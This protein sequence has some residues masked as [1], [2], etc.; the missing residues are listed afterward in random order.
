MG[1]VGTGGPRGNPSG[2]GGS[3]GGGGSSV[4]HGQSVTRWTMHI[5]TESTKDTEELKTTTQ[6]NET[7]SSGKLELLSQFKT[8]STCAK[9][10]F[11]F[12][13][14]L[15]VLHAKVAVTHPLASS[16]PQKHVFYVSFVLLMQP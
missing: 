14:R 12:L 8:R 10:A 2:R 7:L 15:V 3:G 9:R 4:L 6:N 11:D 13:N 5:K 16:A 1:C